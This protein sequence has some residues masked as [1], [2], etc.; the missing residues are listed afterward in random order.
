MA[1]L[2]VKLPLTYNSSDGFTMIKSFKPLIKQNLKMLL[3]TNPGERIMEPAYGVG[4]LT[5]LFRN[6]SENVAG[7]IK[8]KIAAQARAYLPI[9]QITKIDFDMTEPD[10]NKLGISISYKIPK[11]GATD[12]LQFTI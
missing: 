2:A 11:I 12:L 10:N 7:E 5:Y 4:L 9:I 1:S 8:Q 3:L 6:Y